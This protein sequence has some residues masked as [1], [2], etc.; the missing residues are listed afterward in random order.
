M[1]IIRNHQR[2]I[3][4][5]RQGNQLRIDPF[6]FRN[7]VILQLQIKVF[8]KNLLIPLRRFICLI[9]TPVQQM[10]RHLSAQT[11]TEADNTLGVSRQS[12]HVNARLIVLALQMAD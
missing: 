5:R 7:A 8:A 4:F 6:L 1:N 3:A 11:G 12:F 9:V 10:L 2:N